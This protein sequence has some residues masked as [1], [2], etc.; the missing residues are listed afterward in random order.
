MGTLKIHLFGTFRLY[1]E[2][3]SQEIRV[4]PS[5]QSLL[6]FL[7]VQPGSIISRDRVTDLLYGERSEEQARSRLNT[8]LW[9]L[10]RAIEP[11]EISRG[12]YLLCRSNNEVGFNWDSDFWLD[13]V[14]FETRARRILAVPP[15]RLSEAD[16]SQLEEVM[17]L[18]SGDF[19]DGCSDNWVLG[20]RERMR[21]LYMRCLA[22]LMTSNRLHG[23]PEQA[24]PYGERIL[25]ID[26]LREEIHRELMTIY[27]QTGRRAMA[28]RQYEICR[29]SLMS[30]L[31][32]LPM[33]ETRQLHSQIVGEGTILPDEIS[34][35][36]PARL[37]GQL[38]G[39]DPMAGRPLDTL[40]LHRAFE[41]VSSALSNLEETRR[42]IQ[43]VYALLQR[44]Q[45]PS[46]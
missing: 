2:S 39:G 24:L 4:I 46:Q 19:M 10:R 18:Y 23:R 14:E 13:M 37:A 44:L 21:S 45:P 11:A 1:R 43:N 6:A 5:V 38:P 8:A 31:G 29:A 17:S 22:Y 20:E 41:R 27:A 35:H 15:E 9:R 36:E 25:K 26:P 12:T 30:E 16:A 3:S 33:A 34:A 28:V 32:L 42:D 7:L 40:D